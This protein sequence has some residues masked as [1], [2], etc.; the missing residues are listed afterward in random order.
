MRG[1]LGTGSLDAVWG[2]EKEDQRSSDD[3]DGREL[4]GPGK[5]M[6]K[7]GVVMARAWE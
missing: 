7:G 6:K 1:S 5:R 3:E 2:R 4:M